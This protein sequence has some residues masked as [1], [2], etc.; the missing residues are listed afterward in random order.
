MLTLKELFKL[1]DYSA[2]YPDGVDAGD[3][4]RTQCFSPDHDDTD[5]S[6]QVNL[7]TGQYQCL[8]C[9]IKG[10]ALTYWTMFGGENGTGA[11]R[12]EL[13]KEYGGSEEG[14]KEDEP[15]AVI[16]WEQVNKYHHDLVSTSGRYAYVTKVR[17]VS[18]EVLKAKSIGFNGKRYTIP[19]VVDGEIVNIRRYDPNAVAKMKNM[20]GHGEGRLYNAEVLETSDTVVIC[21][22]EWD[23]LLLLS[24]GVPAVTNTSGAGYWKLEWSAMMESK[25]VYICYDV[26][27]AGRLGANKVAQSVQKYAADVHMVTLPLDEAEYPHGDIGDYF[28]KAGYKAED[29][30]RLIEASPELG[31]TVEIEDPEPVD[32]EF[33]QAAKA[34]YADRRIRFT[35]TVSAKDTQPYVIPKRVMA[36]CDM[37]MKSMCDACPVALKGAAGTLEHEYDLTNR[38]MLNMLACSDDAQR[39]SHKRSLGVPLKCTAVDFTTLES[40]NVEE[41][42][43]IP[44]IDSQASTDMMSSSEYVVRRSFYVGHGLETNA[45]YDIECRT[46]A[47]PKQ[48]HATHIVYEAKP[49]IDD[50]RHFTLGKERIDE[51]HRTFG[52]GGGSIESRLAIIYADL[53]ANVTRIFGRRDLHLMVDLVYHSPLFLPFQGRTVKGYVEALVLG[54]SG[55]GKSECSNTLMRHYGVGVK[56]DCKGATVA[57]LLGGVQETAKRWFVS[58]GKIPLNDRRLVVLEEVKGIEVEVLAKLTDMRSSGVAEVTKIEHQRTHARTR[59]LWLSNARAERQIAYY[60]YGVDAIRELFGNLEDVRRLD[61][62]MCVGSGEVDSKLFNCLPEDMPTAKHE[63]TSGL[64]RD[65]VLWCWSRTPKQITFTTEATRAILTA[66]ETLKQEYDSSIP[67]VEPADQRHKLA[68]LAASLAGRVFSTLDGETLVV[69]RPHVDS[70]VAFMRRVYNAPYCRYDEYSATQRMRNAPMDDEAFTKEFTA[71]PRP[72]ALAKGLFNSKTITKQT[73][74]AFAGMSGPEG[75]EFADDFIGF[76]LRHNAVFNY[77]GKWKK[78]FPFTDWLRKAITRLPVELDVSEEGLG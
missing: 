50:L 38:E 28:M 75:K 68:R 14:Q 51:L 21:E 18:I 56:L 7:K 71:T 15:K 65:L 60:D 43:L 35:A 17:G 40:E 9:K 25:H 78:E 26:D 1:I 19:V 48:Q 46:V 44:A 27:D 23:C 63:A 76:L 62:A 49:S 34:Q 33:S 66:A 70:L 31:A 74:S 64:C 32:V 54:D 16:S 52:V 57:G 45:Q 72:R 53:E 61:I 37:S 67:L 55:Q 13:F 20:A 5:P 2:F 3:E 11:S 58:W 24:H 12:Q 22:G 39:M 69:D 4:R 36:T 8:G 77:Y 47:E 29:F 41:I 30:R 10:N 73:I 42:R 59:L 6:L